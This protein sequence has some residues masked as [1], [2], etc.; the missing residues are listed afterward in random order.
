MNKNT[1]KTN[2][3]ISGYDGLST[4][5]NEDEE[6]KNND[7]NNDNISESS[8]G[9]VDIAKDRMRQSKKTKN[10]LLIALF[11]NFI[12]SVLLVGIYAY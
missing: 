2:E 1:T 5:I 8:W 4:N 9:T 11:I 6:E 10:M 7:K 3:V 12:L